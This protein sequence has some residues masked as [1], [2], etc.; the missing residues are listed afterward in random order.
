MQISRSS[1]S[2]KSP[3]M[4]CYH[5]NHGRACNQRS[6]L[7]NIYEDQLAEYLATFTLPEDYREQILSLHAQTR[8]DHAD[9]SERRPQVEASFER[10]TELYQWGDV[11][12]DDYQR[13]RDDLTV[14]LRD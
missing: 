2:G 14:E 1:Q 5:R 10:P 4:Y 8:A 9:D 7:L 12:R 11:D 6:A 3:R 13:E